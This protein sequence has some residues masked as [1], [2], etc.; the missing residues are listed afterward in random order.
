MYFK[1]LFVCAFITFFHLLYTY[2]LNTNTLWYT[3][4]AAFTN[5]TF[6]NSLN[7]RTTEFKKINSSLVIYQQVTKI[8]IRLT[9][10]KNF[11][12]NERCRQ[13]C[14][15][16]L[17]FPDIFHIWG[18]NLRPRWRNTRLCFLLICTSTHNKFAYTSH[19]LIVT[20]DWMRLPPHK[21][22]NPYSDTTEWGFLL[23]STSIQ[24]QI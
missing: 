17:F 9:S 16:Y 8:L 15:N 24:S 19:Q 7:N 12:L 2:L 11:H 4:P 14:R 3:N 23:K 21:Y 13:L 1:I 20:Y 10:L 18:T 5:L 6:I 22:V